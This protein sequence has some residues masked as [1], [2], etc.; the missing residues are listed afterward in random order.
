MV[1]QKVDY[2]RMRAVINNDA[3][4][5]GLVKRANIALAKAVGCK[6]GDLVGC[7]V[8]ALAVDAGVSPEV[9]EDDHNQAYI[10]VDKLYGSEACNLIWMT[11]DQFNDRHT[12]LRALNLL[13]DRF[14]R[15]VFARVYRSDLE[16]D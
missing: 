4:T 1:E 2:Q 10:A 6:P 16:A 7:A 14:E 5:T 13:I 11:N 3:Y 8:F 9:I 15:G 12:R